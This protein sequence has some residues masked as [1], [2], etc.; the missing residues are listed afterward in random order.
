MSQLMLPMIPHGTTVISDLVSVVRGDDR[1]VYFVGLYPIYFHS[2]DDH[3]MFK[4]VTSQ[5]I[6][7]GACRH[8]DIIKTFGVSKSSVN[9]ALKKYRQG[10]IEAFFK[11]RSGGRC[12]T[13][14]TP[15]K[16]EHAQR[17]LDAGLTRQNV[18]E[19]L[20]IGKDTVRK[21]INDGRLI[22]AQN[23]AFNAGQG[24]TK[25]LRNASDA[26]AAD[27]MG[28][29]CT[30]VMDRVFASLGEKDGTETRFESCLDV[31]NAGVLCALPALLANGLLDGV[32][33]FL[34]KIKGYYTIL[35][36][37]L[38]IAFMSLCRI[39]TV[40]KLRGRPPG[41]FG[42]LLGLDRIPEVKC[43]REKMDGISADKAAEKWA[44]HLS[45]KWMETNPETVGT[46]YIDGHV[47]VY[48]GKLTKLPRR[49][50]SRQR[51][52]LRATTDYWVNDAIGRPF[53]V[54][55]K[56]VD[57]G[58]IKTL[59]MDI[60]PRLLDDVAHQ[61]SDSQLK[62]NPYLCRF[63]MVF[64]RE[65]YSPAFLRTMWE[66]QRISCI[67]YHK[68]PGDLWPEHW[69]ESHEVVWPSGETV[70]MRLAEMGS[71][72]GSGTS[73]FWVREIRKLTESGHQ[74]SIISTG[75]ELCHRRLAASMFTRWCQENFFRYM[76]QHFEFDM[77]CEYGVEKLSGTERVVNPAWR[78][79]NKSRNQL[80]NKIRYRRARFAELTL[81]PES[82]DDTKKYDKWVMKKS[83]QLEEIQQYEREYEN[84]KTQLKKIRKHITIDEL[85]EKDMFYKLSSGRKRLTDTIYM[86]AYRSETAMI[87]L[88]KSATVDSSEARS[89]LQDLFAT[90]AD[91]L[92]EVENNILRV[93]VH[94]AS[95]PAA[96][97]SYDKLFE[98]LNETNT[99]YPGTDMQIVYELVK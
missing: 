76:K 1:W 2:P 60:V 86:I 4:L 10:G 9:R 45:K 5:L 30:R 7:S 53:F 40:E 32:E 28:T 34:G 81:H 95:R 22:V 27:G 96:N 55:E 8:S 98:K 29:A 26:L 71:L 68:Y 11:K 50:V 83:E 92:P 85:D 15:E 69:F 57:P 72:V 67:T 97:R 61:P 59:E 19:Q 93:R 99:Q 80:Q 74:T 90:E 23:E 63:F 38:L 64:D 13:V 70:V 36:I 42:K 25:S 17:L 41:E 46:Y 65:G 43:L 77:L 44:A 52:C 49:F 47:R 82:E 6:E 89:L 31:P 21:A 3:K 12:G 14:L 94:N 56:P 84:I 79:L 91:I 78:Q 37:L 33:K 75:Y 73:A 39:K 58:L 51:L 24:S 48:N 35:Q 54:V 16:L 88:L 87:S 18:S 66:K 62:D 20:E